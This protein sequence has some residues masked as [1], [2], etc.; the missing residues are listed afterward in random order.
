MAGE[1]RCKYEQGRRILGRLILTGLGR[2]SLAGE[3]KIWQGI[4][5][6]GRGNTGRGEGH[7]GS[8]QGSLSGRE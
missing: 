1:M 3:G 4:K 5:V 2:V 8:H 6:Q 7:R